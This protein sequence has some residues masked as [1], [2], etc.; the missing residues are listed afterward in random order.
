MLCWNNKQVFQNRIN[1]SLPTLLKT[2]SISVRNTN[3]WKNILARELSILAFS[4]LPFSLLQVDC[5]NDTEIKLQLSGKA[6][7]ADTLKTPL[8]ALSNY[9]FN[10]LRE[11]AVNINNGV[12]SEAHV[13]VLT[14]RE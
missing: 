7:N 3:E 5:E 2:L 14:D 8:I 13:E 9:V 12:V 11:D 6:L 4:V 1:T 10:G